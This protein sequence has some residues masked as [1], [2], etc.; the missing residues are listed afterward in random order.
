MTS[1]LSKV[2]RG[3]EDLPLTVLL[4]GPAGIGKSTFAAGAEAPV[5]IGKAKDLERI[6]ADKLPEPADLNG[7]YASIEALHT[8]KHD[9][10]TLAIDP[11]TYWLEPMLWRHIC[12][13]DNKD[14]I[15]S[16]GY[17][18]GYVAAVD[19]WRVLLARLE[20]LRA[21][22]DMAIVLIAHSGT[23]KISPPDS[24]SYHR[25]SIDVDRRAAALL[26]RWCGEV[27]FANRKRDMV[28]GDDERYRVT[29]DGAALAYAKWNATFNAKS[30]LGLPSTLP[31]A[32]LWQAL[33]P[34]P[35]E[36][37]RN[38]VND[39]INGL[40]AKTA[41]KAR[42]MATRAADDVHRWLS[43]RGWCQAKAQIATQ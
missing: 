2:T 15:E 29:S 37:L 23:T 31:L 18:K 20:A 4:Y 12:K 32:H 8:E 3:R 13:R 24:E 34:V 40:D 26:E 21:K 9:Y 41:D 17:G 28:L 43:L 33:K 6:D 36:Q 42:D 30:R 39:I 38:E 14:S 19:E 35:I 10:R 22:R 25:F 7:V 11:L 5:F 1:L 27:L 16:Y